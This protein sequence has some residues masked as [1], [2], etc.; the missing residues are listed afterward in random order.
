MR[1]TW[2]PPRSVT[3][4]PNLAKWCKKVAQKKEQGS[5]LNMAKVAQKKEQGSRLNMAKAA[6]KVEQTRNYQTWNSFP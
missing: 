3:R 6:Q 2:S 5:R 1:T 4:C